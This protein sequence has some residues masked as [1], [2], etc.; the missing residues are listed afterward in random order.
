M[1]VAQER[2]QRPNK[3]ALEVLDEL[4][5]QIIGVFATN[6]NATLRFVGEQVGRAHTTVWERLQRIPEKRWAGDVAARFPNLK[7]LVYDAI[8]RALLSDD[9]RVACPVALEVGDRIGVI[10][11]KQRVEHSTAPR[12]PEEFLRYFDNLSTDEQ[13]GIIRE[14]THRISG[15]EESADADGGV[16]AG[17]ESSPDTS[18]RAA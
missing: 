8:Q 6:P 16:V 15:T 13:D 3:R 17:D 4:D 18:Q 1:R 11:K 14:I 10:P 2:T 12:T 5:E 7:F 9:D